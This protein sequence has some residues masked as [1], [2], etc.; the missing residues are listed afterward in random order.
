MPLP[1]NELG[2]AMSYVKQT[3]VNSQQLPREYTVAKA[4]ALIN[5]VPSQLAAGCALSL[6]PR[7]AGVLKVSSGRAWVTL[8]LSKNHSAAEAGDHF[9][10]PGYDLPLRAGQR[11]VLESWPTAGCDSISLV[12]QPL[13]PAAWRTH[14]QTTLVGRLLA[15]LGVG[16]GRLAEFL[17]A[18]RTRGGRLEANSPCMGSRG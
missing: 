3:Q 2:Y 5:H 14:W 7:T 12:W 10:Q 6:R 11:L 1:I 13:V 16:W 17:T 9:V 4:I 8:D 18:G 15:P